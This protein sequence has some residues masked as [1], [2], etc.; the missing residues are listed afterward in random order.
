MKELI[1]FENVYKKYG[2]TM[3]LQG[4]SFK[5]RETDYIGLIGN[6]GCGKTTT[7]NIT[8]NL[9]SYDSGNVYLFDKLLKPNYTSYKKYVG[10]VLSEPYYIESFSVSEY[11]RFVCKFQGIRNDREITSKIDSLLGNFDLS[12]ISGE[13]ISGLSSGNKSIITILSSLIHDPPVLI[14]DEPFLNLDIKNQELVIDFLKSIRNE[15]TLLITSHHL[16]LVTG[17]CDYFLIMEDG[18]IIADIRK[19]DFS[20]EPDLKG[21]ISSVLKKGAEA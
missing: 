12:A 2:S 7:I 9:I 20:S 21:E 17:L 3:A 1:R 14:Y 11:F 6:N 19:E 13:R 4:M 10:F 8:G 16:N 5:I 18:K 15:K